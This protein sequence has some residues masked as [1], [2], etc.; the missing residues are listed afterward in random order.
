MAKRNH[1]TV[2]APLVKGINELTDDTWRYTKVNLG[3][4][5]ILCN[6]KMEIEGAT[7]DKAEG[8]LK[9]ISTQLYNETYCMPATKTE[10]DFSFNELLHRNMELEH[11]LNKMD[12]E[13]GEM[14]KERTTD[15][16][17]IRDLEDKLAEAYRA[18]E[19]LHEEHRIRTEI[20]KQNL[21]PALVQAVTDALNGITAPAPACPNVDTSFE[22]GMIIEHELE[23]ARTQNM[24]LHMEIKALTAEKLKLQAKLLGIRHMAKVEF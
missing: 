18:I 17:V 1:R 2:L 19:A 22:D 4:Y 10:P 5:T 12:A 9:A 23:E 20:A 8:Y 16:L 15:S 11:S 13:R 14:L 24:N 3:G 7:L 21:D 6:N